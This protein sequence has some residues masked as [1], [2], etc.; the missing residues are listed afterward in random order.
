MRTIAVIPASDGAPRIATVL[1][2]VLPLVDAVIVVD[3]GSSDDTAYHGLRELRLALV[4]RSLTLPVLL[5]AAL[6]LAARWG[7]LGMVGGH[8]PASAASLAFSAL[9][10]R[11]ALAAEPAE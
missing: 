10:L 8:I 4:Q 11:R 6:V 5:V 3:D 2:A 1:H 9:L 7:A